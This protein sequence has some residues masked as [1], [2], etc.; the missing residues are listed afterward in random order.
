MTLRW[1]IL[2]IAEAFVKRRSS[3]QARLAAL[4]FSKDRCRVAR[5][6]SPPIRVLN[7][8]FGTKSVQGRDPYV[9]IPARTSGGAP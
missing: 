5:P 9:G 4:G 1:A 6:T 2:K 7:G 3:V 8:L